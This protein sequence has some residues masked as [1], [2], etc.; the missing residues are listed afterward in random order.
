MKNMAV[1]LMVYICSSTVPVEHTD[2]LRVFGHQS[3]MLAQRDRSEQ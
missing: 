2:T 1:R 3:A